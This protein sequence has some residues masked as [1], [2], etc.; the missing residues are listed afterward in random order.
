MN[1]NTNIGIVSI[2]NTFFTEVKSIVE[3]GRQQAYTAVSQVMIETYWKIGERIVLQE[4]KGKER[5]DYGTQLIAQLSEELTRTFGKGFSG[6]Y[7]RAFRQ[8]YLAVPDFEIWK[9][10]FPN[11]TWTHIFKTLR[12]ENVTAIRWYLLT[13]SQEMWSVRTLDRNISTQYFERHF[14]QPQLSDPPKEA[15]IP[16]KLE[17]LKSPIV[18]EFLGF[19]KDD[20]FSETD[21]ESAVISHL[22]EFIMEL[23][24]GFAFMGRQELIRTAN[25]D[26]FIDL[27]FYN[28]VLKCYVLIDL[29][30]G[31]IT[32]QDVG[33]MDMYVRMYDDLKRT[34]GD[35]PTIGIVLC[36]ET[37]ADIAKYSI[38]KGNEQ[39]F[40][41]KYK[42]YLPSE[43]ELRREIETQKELFN[44]QNGK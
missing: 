1:E 29:K 16:N 20:S 18:A 8:F 5:A 11:L 39:L 24:R 22:Q 44:L 25:N 34:E 4:Q 21:L 28:V 9:S 19:K 36:S 17:L 42:L 10:R 40:A 7:L 38:L 41:S 35:N 14:K 30:I 33:Q 2:D 32:H 6:R 15:T 37:D 31:K 26:Y 23:G 27:V 12:V 13:A 3:Q 43:E